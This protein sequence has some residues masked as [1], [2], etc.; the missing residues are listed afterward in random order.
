MSDSQEQVRILFNL[1]K[2]EKILD[3]FGCSLVDS[4]PLKG[5][6]YLTE[7]HI[8]F[9]SNLFVFNKKCIIPFCEVS[10]F[11]KTKK[12]IEIYIK[13]EQKKYV[14]NSFSNLL[15]VYKRIK[16]LFRS[17]NDNLTNKI[18]GKNQDKNGTCKIP[19]I[20][21]DS[22]EDS[23]NE[24]FSEEIFDDQALNQTNKNESSSDVSTNNNTISKSPFKEPVSKQINE[25]KST[26]LSSSKK[27]VSPEL[28]SEEKNEISKINLN[29]EKEEEE[30][31]I[32]KSLTNT[33]N[34]KQ[35]KKNSS[36]IDKRLNSSPIISVTKNSPKKADSNLDFDEE[37]IKFTPINTENQFEICRKI[38]D[39][40]PEDLFSKY[41]TNSNSE[42][43]YSK[44]YQIKGT[45]SNINIPDWEKIKDNSTDLDININDIHFEKFKRVNTFSISVAGL[46]LINKSD[47]VKNQVYWIDEKGTY[48]V[49]GSS[50]SQGVPFCDCFKVEDTMEFH[51]YMGGK[52]TVFRA[53]G[54]ATFLKYTFFKS[55]VASQTKKTLTEEI[56][57]WLKFLEQKGEKIE[58]DYVYIP[59]KRSHSCI[60]KIG[61]LNHGLER[62]ISLMKKEEENISTKENYNENQK[63]NRYERFKEVYNKVND[64]FKKEFDFKFT[65]IF[66]L[67]LFVILFLLSI[68]II[69]N[70]QV[71]ELRKGFEDLETAISLV[72]HKLEME[73]VLT[74]PIPY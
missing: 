36:S 44:Y 25:E 16:M 71:K 46:P 72:A 18:S 63:T 41:Q 6:L 17:F 49:R 11:T 2:E 15:V 61:N 66:I 42:T 27:K 10:K 30:P 51:P 26:I 56:E 31:L 65:V 37:E 24:E 50:R 28:D 59:R 62:E 40:S 70:N 32:K 22:E 53:Y 9:D 64:K 5:R 7:F 35:N 57:G 43:S 68:V 47:V 73:K 14:F 39:I 67:G 54:N 13:N 58:G 29:M 69:Q 12:S 52:K 48:Y 21:S 4:I 23:D 60:H 8:C 38:I 74:K 1:R 3:D 34:G 20:L 45:H 33:L 19:I 55:I